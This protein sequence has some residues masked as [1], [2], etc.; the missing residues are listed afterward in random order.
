MSSKLGERARE[1]TEGAGR[2]IKKKGEIIS[3]Y[4]NFKKYVLNSMVY[5]HH[6]FFIHFFVEGHLG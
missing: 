5:M 1:H 4:F 2:R 3:I 6:T